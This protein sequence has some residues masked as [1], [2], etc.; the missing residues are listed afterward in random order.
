M[1][2]HNNHNYI[3]KT[4][5]FCACIDMHSTDENTK[6]SVW[7]NQVVWMIRILTSPKINVFHILD[8]I[9]WNWVSVWIW[10]G[11]NC[12]CNG[13]CKDYGSLKEDKN[14]GSKFLL[15]FNRTVG[16]LIWKS[17]PESNVKSLFPV[18]VLRTQSLGQD[19]YG[20]F[21]HLVNSGEHENNTR[22][23][24]KKV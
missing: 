17:D 19:K 23:T 8:I 11:K 7:N 21:L 5:I 12:F 13:C 22:K 9:L 24:R 18:L 6:R 3:K 14:D 4:G 20:I 10:W 1:V 16:C 2:K 15:H